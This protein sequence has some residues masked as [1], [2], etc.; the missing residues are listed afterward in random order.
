V[1]DGQLPNALPIRLG[2]GVIQIDPALDR[3]QSAARLTE[4]KTVLVIEE[5]AE[6]LRVKGTWTPVADPARRT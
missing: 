4:H 6:E 1:G 3:Q 5:T 2:W